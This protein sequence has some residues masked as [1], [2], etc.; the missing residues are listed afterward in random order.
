[1]KFWGIS[2]TRLCV[3]C[4]YDSI[5]W[6]WYEVSLYVHESELADIP[7]PV[8]KGL[9]ITETRR[10]PYYRCWSLCF[11]S[12]ISYRKSGIMFLQLY[13]PVIPLHTCP[14]PGN[15]YDFVPGNRETEG[16]ARGSHC[17]EIHKMSDFFFWEISLIMS[18]CPLKKSIRWW[19]LLTVR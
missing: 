3:A 18:E 7:S 9:N 2:L 1:M 13:I 15:T 10:F 16:G 17:A 5:E 12:L 4:V 19:Y 14:I 11:H 6:L 8:R